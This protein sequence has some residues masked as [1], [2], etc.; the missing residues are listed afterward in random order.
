MQVLLSAPYLI[1]EINRFKNLFA[2][3]GIDLIVAQV[4]ERLGVDE[5]MEYAGKVDGVICGDDHFNRDVLE[6]F[7][8]RLKVL[9]KW[10]TGIDS[11]DQEAAREFGVLVCNTPGAFTEPVSDSVIGYILA[12][13][14]RL[15]WLDETMKAQVWRKQPGRALYECS[16]GVVGVGRIGKRVLE[17]AYPF[18]MK[19]LGNDI[20]PVDDSFLAGVPVQMV[21]LPELLQGSDFI[22]INCDLNP[23]S[24]HLIDQEALTQVRPGAVLINT[25]RGSVVDEASLVEALR[26]GRLA[27]AALDVFEDEPLPPDSPLRLMDQVLLAPHNANASP[28]AWERTHRSTIMNLFEALGLDRPDFP[29]PD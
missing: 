29:D 7:S 5:L 15:P 25:A 9:S 17:K 19:L 2:R 18:G 22:S 6:A 21:S 16:L 20:E 23:S 14:R 27:G 13:A 11:I 24:H 4:H 28:A 26:Q 10:G 12:F 8:P 1:D 3:A